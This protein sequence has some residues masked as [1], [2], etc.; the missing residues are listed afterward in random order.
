MTKMTSEQRSLSSCI[1]PFMYHVIFLPPACLTLFLSS[2][3]CLFMCRSHCGLSGASV[4]LSVENRESEKQI[5]QRQVSNMSQDRHHSIINTH[6]IQTL[7]LNLLDV[8]IT[9]HRMYPNPIE[10][11]YPGSAAQQ[12]D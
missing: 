3:L 2:S 1:H 10:I 9:I 7:F 12:S 8:P 5:S 11:R 4:L 6:T